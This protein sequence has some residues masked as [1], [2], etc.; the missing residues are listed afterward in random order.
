VFGHEGFGTVVRTGPN[1]TSVK[2]GDV[3]IPYLVPE[4]GKCPYCL[5][6]KTNLC[7]EFGRSFG[8]NPKKTWFKFRGEP[9][10]SFNFLGTFSE[11]IIT[12]T[13]QVQIVNPAAPAAEACCMGCG[14]TTG[15]G[16]ALIVAK[17][18]RESSV[19]VFGLGG[20]GMS[21][22]EGARLAGAKTI[23]GIDINSEKET[24]ARAFGLTHFINGRGTDVVA[25]ILKLTGIGADYAFDCVG[26]AGLFKQGLACLSRGGWAKMISVGVNDNNVPI[27]MVWTD[28]GGRIWQRAF[29]GGAK[30]KDMARFVDM[31]V[32]GKINLGGMVTHRLKLDEI[33]E[34]FNLMRQG[35]TNRA[36]VIYD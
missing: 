34:G 10:A 16:A 9:V 12:P 14:V 31:F 36:V 17:V 33:N 18:E 22:I 2:E 23:I 6:G 28:L 7:T 15:L 20:V 8:P 35:K 27:P 19:V 25:E 30:R 26:D 29:M 21:V 1:V 11:Y 4:C 24:A 5:S 13:D 3:V 32:E